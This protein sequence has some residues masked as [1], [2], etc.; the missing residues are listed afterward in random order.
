VR[1]IGPLFIDE[2]PGT[3]DSRPGGPR[4]GGPGV[5]TGEVAPIRSHKDRSH[6][7]RDRRP[8]SCG[9]LPPQE[10]LPGRIP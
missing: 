1:R 6:V 9:S 5:S 10:P 4:Q 8:C 3:G 7:D 2:A